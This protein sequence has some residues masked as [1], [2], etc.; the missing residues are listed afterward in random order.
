MLDPS[1]PRSLADRRADT[2]R[3]V[4]V[5]AA[6]EL[7][8]ADGLTG[9]SLRTLAGTVGLK[10]PTLYAYFDS[11]HAIYDHMFRQGWEELGVLSAG[12]TARAAS[13]D[14]LRATFKDA[15]RE[16]LDFCTVDPIR[17]QLMNQRVI[18]DYEP[19]ADC[20]ASS[21]A[22]YDAFRDQMMTLGTTN[23]SDLDM[24]TA[25]STGLT[26]QQIANDPGGTRWIQLIDRAVDMFC[27]H[28]GIAPTNSTEGAPS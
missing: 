24:W 17:Y 11:K 12:W 1:E 27:D 7:S 2:T 19:N 3:D 22:V 6:W 4:I 14:D 21:V 15:M 5:E 26:N 13:T 28:L 20:Y 8:R 10:A 9:W 18:P 16:F 25:I 23:E